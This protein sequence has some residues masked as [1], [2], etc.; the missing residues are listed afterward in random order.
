M[1]DNR[2]DNRGGFTENPEKDPPV[3]L[4]SFEI[5]SDKKGK[6][7]FPELFGTTA[8]KIAYKFINEDRGGTY[9]V[10]TNQ[11]RRLYD[12]VKR[13]D[14]NLSVAPEEWQNIEPYIRMIK[15]KVVYNVARAIGK[16]ESEKEVYENLSTFIRHGIDLVKDKE[17]F[18]VFAALFEAVYGFY[19]KINPERQ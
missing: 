1:P 9:A 17:D 18:H 13:L 16:K 19:Y 4:K 15:S 10:T 5:Y 6:I 14:L 2:S 8:E 11:M 12:E 3:D 7:I